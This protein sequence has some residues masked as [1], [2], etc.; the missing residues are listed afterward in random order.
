MGVNLEI[1]KG[2]SKSLIST[3]NESEIFE[4]MYDAVKRIVPESYLIFAKLEQDHQRFRITQ[5]FG[6]EKFIRPIQAL[7]GKDPFD[8][9]F[10][11]SELSKERIEAFE[12]GELFEFK[13]GL[14]EVVNGRVKQ[15]ICIA[16][17]KILGVSSFY[18]IGLS[19]EENYLGSVNIFIPQKSSDGKHLSNGKKIMIET[20]AFQIS[21]SINRLRVNNSLRI[22][23]EELRRSQSNLNQLISLTNDVIWKADG[24]GKNLIDLN[25][26]FEKYLGISAKMIDENPQLWLDIIHPED[27][28]IA[29]AAKTQLYTAGKCECEYRIIKP[30]GELAWLYDRRSILYDSKGNAVQMGGIAFD[31]TDKKLLEERLKL[32]NYALDHSSGAVG[33]ARLDGKIFYVN[34]AF[35]KLMGLAH[36]SEAIGQHFKEYSSGI[37]KPEELMLKL[38]N[39]GIYK[40]EYQPRRKDGS[41]FPCLISVSLVKQDQKP[42]CIMAVFTD[43]SERS[44]MENELREHKQTLTYLLDQKDK[45]LSIVSHDLKSPFSGLLG[46]LDIIKDEYDDYTDKERINL[47]SAIHNSA[48]K[49]YN[50]LME[51]LEWA[52]IHNNNLANK[53]ETV[54]IAKIVDHNI[55]IFKENAVDKQLSIS[56]HI[57][58]AITA[59]I[60][61]NSLNTVVRNLLNNAIK[62]TPEGG[63]IEFEC[64]QNSTS[65]E[66]IIRDNGIGINKYD[67][68]K[69]LSIEESFTT[70]GTDNEIGT[71]LGLNICNE[72]IQ[73]NGWQLKVES[74]E[75]VGTSFS[76]VIDF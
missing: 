18:A 38:Q 52:K 63:K 72:L 16:I 23:E 35:I 1:L 54:S 42:I 65:L 32:I 64:L 33:M 19:V 53:K 14:Y 9:F 48:Y 41:S 51:L 40:G 10:P 60:N 24:N 37:I 61:I 36:A 26:S 67:L 27:L 43:I 20:I 47:I 50:L 66:L 31:I 62:F 71:G 56:N 28:E 73:K 46:L 22:K 57:P 4:I 59:T 76:I 58:S 25:N 7:I 69:I 75:N 49:A 55:G 11:L 30:D 6:F 68:Q 3:K 2:V 15:P 44:K 21:N 39:G 12:R 13:N 74:E 45:F 17:E 5:S 70:P 34:D 29:T 8:L